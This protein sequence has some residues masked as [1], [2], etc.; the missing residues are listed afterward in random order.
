MFVK[1]LDTESGVVKTDFPGVE[2]FLEG[3]GAEG[4][5]ANVIFN[6]LINQMQKCSLDAVKITSFVSDGASV[7]VGRS[8]GVAATLKGLNKP[9]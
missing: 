4:A 2:S 3:E 5:N 6:C 7:M 8:N 9:S 1:Y